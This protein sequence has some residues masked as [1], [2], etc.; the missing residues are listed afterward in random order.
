VLFYLKVIEWQIPDFTIEKY[1]AKLRE[2]YQVI[3]NVGYFDVTCHR[4]V[5]VA[6]KEIP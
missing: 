1:E 5:L 6:A 3:T 2:L 4:F